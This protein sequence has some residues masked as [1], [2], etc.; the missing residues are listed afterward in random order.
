MEKKLAHRRNSSKVHKDKSF[1][2]EKIDTPNTHTTLPLTFLACYRHFG[3]RW[4]V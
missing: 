3:E 2:V 1:K 4:R